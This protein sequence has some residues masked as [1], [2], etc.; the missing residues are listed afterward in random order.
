[1]LF[2]PKWPKT[3]DGILELGGDGHPGMSKNSI[4]ELMKMDDC[5]ELE[6]GMDNYPGLIKR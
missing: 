4:M 5:Q 6:H 1:M 2:Q 3:K